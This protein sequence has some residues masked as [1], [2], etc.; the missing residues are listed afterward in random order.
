MTQPAPAAPAPAAP[1]S[2]DGVTPPAVET[3]AP[4][5]PAPAP[6][7]QTPP[8]PAPPAKAED[9]TSEPWNDPEKAKETIQRLRR[10]NGASRTNA[11]AQAAQE[12]KTEVLSEIAKA[13]GLGPEEAPTLEGVQ[14]ELATVAQERD[15]ARA[16]AEQERL[17]AGIVREAWEQGVNPARLDY[18]QFLLARRAD[19][20][21]AQPGDLGA[22]IKAAITDEITKDSSL[23]VSGAQIGTGGAGFGG[24][25]AQAMTRE[26][27]QKLPLREQTRIYRENPAEYAR[28]TA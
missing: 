22:T 23:K 16:T 10:E 1:A 5:A 25:D 17:N 3:P 13:L 20:K 15:M 26:E 19:L 11:K 4:P 8:A 18:L 27:F 24:S 2:P 6:A 9:D 14:G 12:A 7:P 28:L 21:D